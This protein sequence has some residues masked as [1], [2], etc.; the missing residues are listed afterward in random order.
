VASLLLGLYDDA[1]VLRHVGVVSSFT[2]TR[3]HELLHELAPY[4]VE[5]DEH[6]WS[7]G[8]AREGGSMGRLPGSA[9]RWEPGM[10]L[11]WVPLRPELVCEVAYDQVGAGRWRHPG[12]FLRWR[13]DRDARS[14]TLDQLGVA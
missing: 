4:V 9:G 12:R 8:F 13:P 2:E 14:C 6:P 5:L 10:E 1:G 11:D 7:A 3:R